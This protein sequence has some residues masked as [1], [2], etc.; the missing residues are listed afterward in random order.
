MSSPIKA[1]IIDDEALSADMLEYLVRKNVAEISEIK[2]A[3][4]AVDG[5]ELIRTF[6]PEIVF[7]DIHMPHISGFELLEKFPKPTFSVIFTT[8]FNKYAIR[9]I[10]FSALDYLLKPVDP[11]ELKLAVQRYIDRRQE[12]LQFRELYNNF[13]DNLKSGES[14]NYRLALQT[15]GGIRLISPSEI[16]RCEGHNNYTHF[17][18]TDQSV[19]VT[20]KTI[21]EYEDILSE[22]NFM[23]V[24]K[25]HLINLDFVEE[26]TQD[27][28]IILKNKNSVEVSRRRRAEVAEALRKQI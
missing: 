13:L 2:K 4:S 9:A 28:R 20:S 17:F 19:I 18:L 5:L 15:H 8:A 24:H 27:H 12:M 10:R 7:L 14:K 26:L 22:H 11:D 3:T 1:L 16:I 25:S 21:K 23:R 6:K